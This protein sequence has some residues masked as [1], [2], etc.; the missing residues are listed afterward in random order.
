MKVDERKERARIARIMA[1]PNGIFVFGSNLAGIHGA[2]AA[3]AALDLYGAK[4]GQG[5]GR[6]GRSYAIPTKGHRLETLPLDAIAA[7]VA[8]FLMYAMSAPGFDFAVTRVGRG[9]AGY[10][11]ELIAP[12]FKYARGNVILP[13]GWREVTL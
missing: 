12:M 7:H 13:D 8:R 1:Q 5:Q 3:R 11:D 6:Q 10:T 2:G 9:L 4:Y